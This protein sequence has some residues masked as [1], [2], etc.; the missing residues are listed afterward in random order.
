[1]NEIACDLVARSESLQ[2]SGNRQIDNTAS[3][4][5]VPTSRANKICVVLSLIVGVK[6]NKF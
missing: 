2:D 3:A 6:L 1:M 5:A 4:A